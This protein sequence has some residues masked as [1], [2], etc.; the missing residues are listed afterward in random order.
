MADVKFIVEG[1]EI[2]AHKLILGAGCDFFKKMFTSNT[3]KKISD[4]LFGKGGMIESQ[5]GVI[6]IP[7]VKAATFNGMSYDFLFQVN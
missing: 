7:D 4:S 5:A 3:D 1:Q 2:L 6:E